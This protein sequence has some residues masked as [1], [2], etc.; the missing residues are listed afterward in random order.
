LKRGKTP[1]RAGVGGKFPE[2][3]KVG[4]FWDSKRKFYAGGIHTPAA[5][6]REKTSG[7]GGKNK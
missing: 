7:Y 2:G 4:G 3:R 5:A 6:L 1:G